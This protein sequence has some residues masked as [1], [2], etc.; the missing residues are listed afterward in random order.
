MMITQ[1]ITSKRH[2]DH[3][4]DEMRPKESMV[5]EKIGAQKS[6]ENFNVGF[7][8]QVHTTTVVSSPNINNT[9][10]TDIILPT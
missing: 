8:S 10:T 5:T 9:E 4:N 1:A 6:Q 3:S 2:F 7:L